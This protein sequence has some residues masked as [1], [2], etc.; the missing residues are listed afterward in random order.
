MSR[1][2]GHLAILH[3][4]ESA[5]DHAHENPSTSMD[6]D[7]DLDLGAIRPEDDVDESARTSSTEPARTGGFSGLVRMILYGFGFLMMFLVAL[8]LFLRGNKGPSMEPPMSV[9]VPVLESTLAGPIKRDEVVGTDTPV[10][11]P[12][13]SIAPQSQL[14]QHSVVAP[15]LA[16]VTEAKPAIPTQSATM[17]D[18]VRSDIAAMQEMLSEHR[19]LIQAQLSQNKQFQAE[20]QNLRTANEVTNKQ[21]DSIATDLAQV[22]HSLDDL[23]VRQ[24]RKAAT[25]RRQLAVSQLQARQEEMKRAEPPPFRV[26]TVTLWGSDYIATVALDSGLQRDLTTGELLDGWKV[27]AITPTAVSVIRLHDGVQLNLAAGV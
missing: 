17:V 21:V 23:T 4:A 10:E 2:T 25:L 18:A 16:P 13:K 26:I 24:A 20:L 12:A 11:K 1:A 22:R 8:I 5:S 15:P 9:A 7:P 14:T 6:F 27:T 3:T 19:E